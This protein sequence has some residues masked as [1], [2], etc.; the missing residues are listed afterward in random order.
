MTIPLVE[1]L[2]SQYLV[3]ATSDHWLGSETILPLTFHNLVL[4]E[5]YPPH[6]GE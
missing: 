4:P 3:K 1:P 2:P 6:T 5:V